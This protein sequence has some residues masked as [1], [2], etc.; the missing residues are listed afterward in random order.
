MNETDRTLTYFIFAEIEFCK[1]NKKR[2]IKQNF[3]MAPQIKTDN[4]INQIECTLILTLQEGIET[5][6]LYR[7]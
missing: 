2:R 6:W 5:D 4:N 3:K 7:R 1:K